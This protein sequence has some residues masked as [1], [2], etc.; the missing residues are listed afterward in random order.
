MEMLERMPS[1][2]MLNLR[3][4]H[5]YTARTMAIT[6]PNIEQGEPFRDY[7]VA[8]YFEDNQTT[9]IWVDEVV[10]GAEVDG[11][12]R[13]TDDSTNEIISPKVVTPATLPDDI[14]YIISASSITLPVSNIRRNIKYITF[15]PDGSS[16]YAVLNFIDKDDSTSNSSNYESIVVYP[17][18]G[19]ARIYH[20]EKR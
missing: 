13:S 8:L 10:A 16:I 1:S 14:R 4:W 19:R 17:A 11:F 20:N 7:V 9:K 3:F 5:F 12:I 15:R 18:T 6:Q 2:G